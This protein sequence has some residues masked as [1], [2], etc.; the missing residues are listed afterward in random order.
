MG[1][2]CVCLCMCVRGW[3]SEVV[4]RRKEDEGVLKT[5][6]LEILYNR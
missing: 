4:G 5:L 6:L 1:V 2:V 3:L